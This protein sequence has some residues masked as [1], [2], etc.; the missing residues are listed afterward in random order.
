MSE[1]IFENFIDTLG[2]AFLEWVV[3]L[4][5]WQLEWDE[6]CF[7]STAALAIVQFVSG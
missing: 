5:G 7:G 4:R 3:F 6:F 2:A 1:G